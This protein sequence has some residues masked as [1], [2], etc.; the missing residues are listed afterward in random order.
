MGSRHVWFLREIERQNLRSAR[1]T[2]GRWFRLSFPTVGGLLSA[3]TKQ[4]TRWQADMYFP[5]QSGGLGDGLVHG[6]VGR[7]ADIDWDASQREDASSLHR[8]RVLAGLEDCKGQ[9]AH[10]AGWWAEEG[11]RR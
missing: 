5:V 11:R 8:V 9:S 2:G 6:R 7:V 4:T 1:R 10:G 3:V